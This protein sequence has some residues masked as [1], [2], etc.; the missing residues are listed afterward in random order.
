MV[1][2]NFNVWGNGSINR[3]GRITSDA[4]TY[5][6][7]HGYQSTG[8]N[9]GNNYKPANWMGNIAQIIRQ[10]ESNANI[11]LVDWE[12]GASSLWY[13]TSAARTRDVANQ[14]ATYLVNNGVDPTYTNLIGHS[15]GAHIAGFTGSAYRESTGRS[16]AQIVGLDPAGPEFEGKA[17]SE[18]LD[19][20]DATRVVSIHTSE[21]LGYDARL[22]TLDVYANWN[23][24]F[25]PGQ[26]NFAGNHSYA[27]TLYTELLQGNSFTQSNRILLNLNTVVNAGFTGQNNASTKNNKGIVALNLL[28]T[29]NN[30]TQAGG[31]ANDTI[32]GNAGIDYITGGDGDDSVF[33]DSGNDL[34]YGGRG[35]DSVFGGTGSDRLFGDEGDDILAGADIAARGVAEIDRLTGGTGSDQFVLGTTISVFYSDSNTN[36]FGVND[37]AIIADFNVLEDTLQLSGSKSS[38]SLGA[39]PTGLAIGTALFL[40]ETSPELLAIIQGSSNL[41]LSASYFLTV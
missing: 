27:H 25:Q 2:V 1:E 37:Y 12:Q 15:L 32:R 5:V 14:L 35:N 16:L 6:I 10:R 33:G 9:A 8:G 34:V 20:S 17:A 41:S 7:I 24:L 18:R 4:P 40:N 13:P 38:Y 3:S 19:P 21:T 30:D 39:V 29:A 22:A 23:D 36:T 31:A 28:G 11:I 26:W